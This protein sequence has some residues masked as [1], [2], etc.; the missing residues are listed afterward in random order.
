MS[1]YYWACATP[2]VCLLLSRAAQN[3][4]RSELPSSLQ[5]CQDALRSLRVD[6]VFEKISLM[7]RKRGAA[8]GVSD[9]SG[10]PLI[11]YPSF[12]KLPFIWPP[13]HLLREAQLQLQSLW[14]GQEGPKSRPQVIGY[15][16]EG[17][18]K[19][20]RDLKEAP[21]WNCYHTYAFL[22]ETLG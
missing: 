21:H 13:R 17:H 14:P 12:L 3:N 20:A 5:T 15:S 19:R 18:L 2:K 6:P 22:E 1:K 4:L 8:N 9:L 11:S 16:T 7:V 10:P